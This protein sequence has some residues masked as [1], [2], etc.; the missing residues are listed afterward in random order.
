[1]AGQIDPANLSLGG[2][3]HQGVWRGGSAG[4]DNLV[5]KVAQGV[6]HGDCLGCIVLRHGGVHKCIAR[7]TGA[8]VATACIGATLAADPKIL[9]LVQILTGAIVLGKSEACFAEAGRPTWLVKAA[10]KIIALNLE[11]LSI[12]S[13]TERTSSQ[14]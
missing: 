4:G 6:V 14:T 5:G 3:V 2:K 11:N 1:M 9:T 8:I 10:L 13:I 12:Q 7:S